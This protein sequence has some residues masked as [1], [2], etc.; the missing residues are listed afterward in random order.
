MLGF[1]V[2]INSKIKMI[3]TEIV[4]KLKMQLLP[5]LIIVLLGDGDDDCGDNSD[6]SDCVRD[7]CHD[8]QWQCNNRKCIPQYWKW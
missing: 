6:E 8:Y 1:K 3:D 7:S 4:L 2:K 5:H